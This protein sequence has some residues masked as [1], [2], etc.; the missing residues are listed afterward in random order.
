MVACRELHFFR[1]NVFSVV[2][3]GQISAAMTNKQFLFSFANCFSY[4]QFLVFFIRNNVVSWRKK[5]GE[6]AL[7][8]ILALVM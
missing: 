8:F 2:E 4:D 3:R 6:K 7:S 5:P 1:V